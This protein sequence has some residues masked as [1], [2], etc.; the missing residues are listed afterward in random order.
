MVAMRRARR[1]VVRRKS[2]LSRRTDA[3]SRL[4]KMTLLDTD[5]PQSSTPNGTSPIRNRNSSSEGS[6]RAPDSH[7]LP[8]TL[9]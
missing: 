5:A 3:R 1:R 8:R 7:E 4:D 9:T 6:P 2:R